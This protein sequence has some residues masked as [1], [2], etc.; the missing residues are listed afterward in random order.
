MGGNDDAMR[1]AGRPTSGR[2][3]KKKKQ[4]EAADGKGAA[5]VM[6]E[7]PA[8]RHSEGGG[9]GNPS[10][11]M[12][13]R[14]AAAEDEGIAAES[15][16]RDR[17]DAPMRS[18]DKGKRANKKRKGERGEGTTSLRG[19][20]SLSSLRGLLGPFRRLMPA[21]YEDVACPATPAA[22][23]RLFASHRLRVFQD[24]ALDSLNPGWEPTLHMFQLPEKLAQRLNPRLAALA[25]GLEQRTDGLQ[26]S[27]KAGGFHS[28]QYLF[29]QSAGDKAVSLLADITTAAV[30]CAEKEEGGRAGGARPSHSWVNV[31]RA[32]AY[33]GL[34]D[35]AGATWSGCYYVR[36]PPRS[37]A[38]RE[39]QSGEFIARV[40]MG[41]LQG[42]APAA[43]LS[44]ARQDGEASLPRAGGGGQE[45]DVEGW[46]TYAA[47]DP[48]PGMLLL[49]PSWVKHCVMPLLEDGPRISIA[50]NVGE[51]DEEAGAN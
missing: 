24:S 3:K 32:G 33:N 47:V 25:L 15:T 6:K 44:A 20:S 39:Q 7:S 2:V 29:E 48:S 16:T 13:K 12:D 18:I 41:G 4:R 8:G 26:V 46:C 37:A 38:G 42:A 30:R 17:S 1:S 28:D 45:H 5:P 51:Q 19:G 50:F 40:A 22:L 21:G 43:V 49:F 34:H 23:P 35:H 36:C 11:G 9:G 27:N 31:S 10:K 14:R